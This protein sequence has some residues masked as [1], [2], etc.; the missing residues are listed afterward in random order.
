MAVPTRIALIDAPDWLMQL[1]RKGTGKGL[2]EL[3][4]LRRLHDKA[5]SWVES[6][7]KEQDAVSRSDVQQARREL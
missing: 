3:Y 1:Y 2:N 4:Q 6:W 7:C 5:P